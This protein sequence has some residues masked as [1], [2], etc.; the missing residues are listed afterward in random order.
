MVF[1][2]FAVLLLRSLILWGRG[3]NEDFNLLLFGSTQPLG[4]VYAVLKDTFALLVIA[5]VAIFF[6]YRV[7]MFYI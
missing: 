4:M 1:S 2:G 3:Y 5:G 7:I 6:Y